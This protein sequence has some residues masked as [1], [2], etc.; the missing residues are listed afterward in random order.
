MS[1]NNLESLKV[2]RPKEAAQFAYSFDPD[3]N[4]PFKKGSHAYNE[5]VNEL[6]NGRVEGGV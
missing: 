4:N 5:F 1:N 3:M 2:L 6:H